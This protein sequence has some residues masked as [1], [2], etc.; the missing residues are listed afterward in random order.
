MFGAVGGAAQVA[1]PSP[2]PE[3]AT[4]LDYDAA[5]LGWPFE[6]VPYGQDDAPAAEKPLI[7][8]TTEWSQSNAGH[9]FGDHL[10]DEQRRAVLEYL[11]TL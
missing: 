10:T 9:P 2:D 11:K 3:A 1:T 7:Y 5:A 8:D 4:L 6:D